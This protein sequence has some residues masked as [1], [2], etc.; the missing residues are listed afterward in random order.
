MP[1][2]AHLHCFLCLFHRKTSVWDFT[3]GWFSFVR[4]EVV[5]IATHLVFRNVPAC[6][7]LLCKNTALTVP[8]CACRYIPVLS[9]I[10][11]NLVKVYVA[12]SATHIRINSQLHTWIHVYI[13]SCVHMCIYSS[14]H[15]HMLHIKLI[16]LFTCM[17]QIYNSSNHMEYS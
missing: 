9:H 6:I 10:F 15:V 12:C 7:Q 5:L 14:L 8:K 17:L 1:N 13:L 3:R 2:S 4:V 11:P 16:Y